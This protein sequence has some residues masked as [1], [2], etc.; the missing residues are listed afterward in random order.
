M[1]SHQRNGGLIFL[2]VFILCQT[3]CFFWNAVDNFLATFRL[4]FMG[5]KGARL[6]KP[7]AQV[8]NVVFVGHA[9]MWFYLAC[10]LIFFVLLF[11]IALRKA[12]FFRTLL[13]LDFIS[14]LLGL[15]GYYFWLTGGASLTTTEHVVTLIEPLLSSGGL[16]LLIAV[17]S[18][19][20]VWWPRRA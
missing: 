20:N 7:I 8:D 5:A 16:M 4:T 3:F 19:R 15:Y 14:L 1:S 12:L 18:V 17:P 11:G 13:V 2:C 10:C 6:V 9:L